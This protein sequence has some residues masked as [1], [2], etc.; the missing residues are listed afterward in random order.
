M[1]SGQLTDEQRRRIE[2]N[3]R[4]AL[5]K[6]AARLRQQQERTALSTNTASA[7]FK[8]NN[9]NNGGNFVSS[10]AAQ[11]PRNEN[12]LL[13]SNKPNS[14][15]PQRQMSSKYEGVNK[16]SLNLT[17]SVGQASNASLLMNGNTIP[18]SNDFSGKSQNSVVG[19]AKP[20]AKP[21]NDERSSRSFE[22]TVSQFYRP[23]NIPGSNSS[24]SKTKF[25]STNPGTNPSTL[26]SSGFAKS[27]SGS[28]KSGVVSS[29][30]IKK[31][32]KEVKG[33]CVLMNRERFTVV[34]PYQPQVIGIFKTIPSRSYGKINL[35][36]LL[37]I[38]K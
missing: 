5:E 6:R 4:K 30:N 31:P 19:A 10:N 24:S 21:S 17:Q 28:L 3:R 20:M 1:L 35:S 8:L 37:Y 11:P 25:E 14:Y 9:I 16:H 12:T 13:S 27:N 7:T 26:S 38:P 18:S 2:E 22:R 36:G 15:V 32:E 34:V 33:N 23:Q 29:V